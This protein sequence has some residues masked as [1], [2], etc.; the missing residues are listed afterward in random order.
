MTKTNTN[1]LVDLVVPGEL[2]L[3]LEGDELVDELL[4]Y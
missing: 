4:E 1:L 3:G 2:L